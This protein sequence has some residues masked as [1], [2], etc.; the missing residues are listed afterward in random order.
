MAPHRVPF[1][2]HQ[3][4]ASENH[5]RYKEGNPVRWSIGKMI[6][7]REAP[8][9]KDQEIRIPAGPVQTIE[10]APHDGHTIGGRAGPT[11]RAPHHQG[12]PSRANRHS[13]FED[14]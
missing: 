8:Q 12:H 6:H 1:S 13:G 2:S 10:R 11:S 4:Q 14:Q 7:Q 9:D 3:P 5:P